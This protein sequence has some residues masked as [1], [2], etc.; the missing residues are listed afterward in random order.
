[1]V[2]FKRRG[3]VW[4]EAGMTVINPDGKT[5][6][7]TLIKDA[8]GPDN[9]AP[10]IVTL[11]DGVV[12]RNKWVVERHRATPLLGERNPQYVYSV[13]NWVNEIDTHKIES[14]SYC[15]HDYYQPTKRSAKN[16]AQNKA[17]ELNRRDRCVLA[18]V[19]GGV[20]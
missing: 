14:Y 13:F 15:D 16:D 12:L 20:C 17:E 8:M 19:T 9:P 5:T 3:A 11:K 1:M 6:Y 4:G 2:A 7:S 18:V 10:I